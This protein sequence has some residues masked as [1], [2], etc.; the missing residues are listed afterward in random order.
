MIVVLYNALLDVLTFE[1]DL[2]L[3]PGYGVKQVGAVVFSLQ[4]VLVQDMLVLTDE[5]IN[6]CFTFTSG[7]VVLLVREEAHNDA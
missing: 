6:D 2:L 4:V 3:S 1:N 5:V 7:L